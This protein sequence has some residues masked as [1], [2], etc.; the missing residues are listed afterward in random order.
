[1]AGELRAEIHLAI[2]REF[3]IRITESTWRPSVTLPKS[4]V[5][6]CG[7]ENA[8]RQYPKPPEYPPRAIT[9]EY[10]RSNINPKILINI[11][12]RPISCGHC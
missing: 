3:F 9:V 4:I 2:P 7:G 10:V 6:G 1:M 11:C 8:V 5:A 12:P